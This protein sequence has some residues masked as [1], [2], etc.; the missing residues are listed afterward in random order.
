MNCLQAIHWQKYCKLL[1]RHQR[2]GQNFLQQWDRCQ[3]TTSNAQPGKFKE[4]PSPQ[5]RSSTGSGSLSVGKRKSSEPHQ[6]HGNSRGYMFSRFQMRR[7]LLHIKLNGL[8]HV[9]ILLLPSKN[10]HYFPLQNFLQFL[11]N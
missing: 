3:P 4:T 9:F 10:R 1:Y 2:L 8:W 7:E 6:P 11:A 5:A